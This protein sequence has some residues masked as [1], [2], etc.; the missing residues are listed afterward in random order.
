MVKKVKNSAKQGKILAIDPGSKNIGVAISDPD[1][2]MAFARSSI[3]NT[4]EG[5]GTLVQL[6][7]LEEISTIIVGQPLIQGEHAINDALK[8]ELQ[9]QLPEIEFIDFNED[10]ST[11]D[12]IAE[13]KASG[14]TPEEI[15]EMK[16]SY[17][18][19]KILE[20]YIKAL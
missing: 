18:A 2:V 11:Q 20:N 14:A 17:A 5:L 10:F 19:R 4:P 16:D 13:L 7:Q 12:A 3:Q 1:L 6:C 15:A 8:K 9:S